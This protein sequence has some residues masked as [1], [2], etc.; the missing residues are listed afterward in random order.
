MPITYRGVLLLLAATMLAA[1]SSSGNGIT[2]PSAASGQTLSSNGGVDAVLDS[3][4]PV[5]GGRMLFHKIAMHP[6]AKAP[7]FLINLVTDGPNQS[8]V[9][10][11]NCVNG[12]ST[13]YN[14]GMTGPTSY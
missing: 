12:A 5:A 8:G 13:S 14:V 11:I 4:P 10:C 7:A 9:P 3:A 6:K 1:C 2:M